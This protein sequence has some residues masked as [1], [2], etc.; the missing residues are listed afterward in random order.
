MHLWQSDVRG[1][2]KA[3]DT[4]SHVGKNTI[5]V[6]Q[7]IQIWKLQKKKVSVVAFARMPDRKMLFKK[8]TFIAWS[9]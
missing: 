5:S 7:K 9:D 4:F 6:F 1:V 3:T 2:T 8:Y